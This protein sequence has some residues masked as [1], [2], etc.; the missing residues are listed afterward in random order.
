MVASTSVP[1][2]PRLH[3]AGL[4]RYTRSRHTGTYV[5][6]YL[7]ATAGLDTQAGKWATVCETHGNIVNHQT[8]DHA[9]AWAPRPDGWCEDCRQQQEGS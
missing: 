5:G 8:L 3:Y 6:V 9:I 1:A 4:R 7:A 2:I